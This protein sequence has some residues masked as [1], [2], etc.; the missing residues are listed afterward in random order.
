MD[1]EFWV[2]QPQL[3]AHSASTSQ[4]CYVAIVSCD[5]TKLVKFVNSNTVIWHTVHLSWA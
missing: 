2:G 3:D 5:K 1:I 4:D